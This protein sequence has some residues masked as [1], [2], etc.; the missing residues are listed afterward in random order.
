MRGA[1]AASSSATPRARVGVRT[2]IV[3]LRTGAEPRTKNRESIGA[4]FYC[5]YNDLSTPTHHRAC[6][7]HPRRQVRTC[8][9][10]CALRTGLRTAN[11]HGRALLSFARCAADTGTMNA[12]VSTQDGAHQLLDLFL[13]G[14]SPRTLDAY[15]GDLNRFS[16]FVGIADVTQAAKHL[17]ALTNGEANALVL[18]YRAALIQSGLAP[19]TTNRRLAALRSLVQLACLLGLVPWR[20]SVPG[21]E[22]IPYRDTRGP[23]KE[24]Y[25]RLL[26]LEGTISAKAHRDHAILRLLFDL[27][28][29]REEVVRLDRDDVDLPGKRISILGKKRTQKEWLSL[30]QPTASAL[31]DW[32]NMRGEG[33]GALF[34]NLDRRGRKER[35]TGRSVHRIV[36]ALGERAGLGIV[37]PHGL[38]H[39]AITAALDLTGGNVRAVQRFSRHRDLRTLT[40]YDDNRLDL[41]GEIARRLAG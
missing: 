19:A 10:E 40:L 14:C 9:P 18:R 36:R 17:L 28:L 24:G 25:Q 3:N 11:L 21:I 26:A 1:E 12:L 38:R 37:R 16:E 7:T 35:L 32:I 30:P 15:R 5:A 31:V 33:P 39:A 4:N 27:A 29:R 34:I 41:G 6:L 22:A 2:S 20:L 13:S 23:G 8:V